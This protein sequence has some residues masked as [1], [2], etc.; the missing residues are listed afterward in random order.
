MKPKTKRV[1]AAYLS[2]TENDPKN[3]LAQSPIPA[4]ADTL[5]YEHHTSAGDSARRNLK[6]Y[7]CRLSLPFPRSSHIS[8]A[9]PSSF[10][11]PTVRRVAGGHDLPWCITA[12]HGLAVWPEV[13]MQVSWSLQKVVD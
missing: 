7:P 9:S 3:K 10:V 5:A 4:A 11:V 12:L 1:A 13:D 2:R 6:Y 8:P